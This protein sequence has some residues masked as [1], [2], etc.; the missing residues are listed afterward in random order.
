MTM[1]IDR[2]LRPRCAGADHGIHFDHDILQGCGCRGDDERS[3]FV[4]ST[5]GPQLDRGDLPANRRQG[6]VFDDHVIGDRRIDHVK[7]VISTVGPPGGQ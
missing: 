5:A 4:L 3:R 2:M 7:G 1:R 6:P